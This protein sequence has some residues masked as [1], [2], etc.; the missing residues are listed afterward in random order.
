MGLSVTGGPTD[1]IINYGETIDIDDDIL[2]MSKISG[3]DSVSCTGIN[4]S[5][6]QLYVYFTDAVTDHITIGAP[7]NGTEQDEPPHN[8]ICGQTF[9]LN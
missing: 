8:P 4:S 7:P 9:K 6:G 1:F 2:L 3:D 5:S